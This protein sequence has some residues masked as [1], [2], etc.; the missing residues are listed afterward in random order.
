VTI[1]FDYRTTPGDS[2]RLG[3][4]L[5]DGTPPQEPMRPQSYPLAPSPER[6]TTTAT[7]VKKNL[8]AAGRSYTFQFAA[9][10]SFDAT[11]TSAVSG[12]KMTI[13]IE[14]WTAGD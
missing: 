12:N 14:S 8:P 2:A 7:W 4:G 1:T 13:V 11:G 10:P 5:N 3:L 6:R 9:A